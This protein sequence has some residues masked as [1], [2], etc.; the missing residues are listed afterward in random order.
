MIAA[1]NL[2]D[3]DDFMR[4]DIIDLAR[5][6]VSRVQSYGFARLALSMEEWRN[7]KCEAGTVLALLGSIGETV[8]LEADLLAAHEDYS[9]YD[10]L[11]LLEKKHE[12]NPDFEKT[13]KGNAENTY[14]RSYISELFSGIY[15]PEMKVYTE[16]VT[17]KIN[18]DDRSAWER[19]A[20]FDAQEKAI[21]DKF[22]ETPLK[23]LAPDHAK[24]FR[25]LSA[26]LEKLAGTT[27]KIIW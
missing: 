22:Y 10:A 25:N 1:L 9:L 8:R 4:R 20:E 6:T 18:A 26:T 19:P 5:T 11:K 21:Q 27:E 23:K 12:T 7:G 15:Q 13:L 3:L 24:A 14:C 17:A 16:W 2:N